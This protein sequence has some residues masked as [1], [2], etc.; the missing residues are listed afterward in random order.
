MRPSSASATRG[1]DCVTNFGCGVDRIEPSEGGGSL[2]MRML[3]IV[4]LGFSGRRSEESFDC[5]APIAS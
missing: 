3:A 5:I 2:P 1:V 4:R